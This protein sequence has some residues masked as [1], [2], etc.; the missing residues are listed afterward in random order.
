MEYLILAIAMALLVVLLMGKEYLNSLSFQKKILEKM[1]QDY[2]SLPTRKYGAEEL[3]HICCYYEKHRKEHMIDDITWNDLNMDSIYQMMNSSC[4]AAGDEYLYYRLRTPLYD[5]QELK[6]EERQIRY[7]AE[8]EKER[9]ALQQELWKMGRSGKHS[10]YEYLE[11]LDTL[12]VRTNAKYYL[13]DLLLLAGIGIMFFSLPVGIVFF[14]A[15]SCHNV[16]N[17]YKEYKEVEPYVTSFYYIRRM[18]DGAEQIGR[19]PL[20][21]FGEQ[22][23]RLKECCRA[24]RAF[25]RNSNLVISTEKGSGNPLSVVIDYLRMFLYLD[26]IQF[27][28]TLSELR[29]H[30]TEVD[31]LVT[32]TGRM[33][34]AIVIGSYRAYL[35]DGWCVPEF[36]TE[37]S[38]KAFLQIRDAVHPLLT[39]PVANSIDAQKSVLLTGS[40]ASG[41][42]TFLRTVGVCALLAQTIHTCPAKEYRA[43]LFYIYSSMSLKDDVQSGNSYYM[44][45]VKSIKRIL[46]Q[47]QEAGKEQMKVLCFVDEV[48]RGT[49]TVERISASTQILRMLAR[50]NVVCFAATHDGELTQLLQSV[51]DNYH[52]EEKMEQDDILFPYQLIKGPATTR[53]AIAL[54]RI[55]G[56]DPGIVSQAEEMAKRFLDSGEWSVS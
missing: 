50:E 55:L 12:G 20:D 14:L 15:V 48:L 6:E 23:N 37:K 34:T 19:L 54:L 2:G 44:A 13:F 35:G 52:F 32:I 51:Y 21:D 41:K 45:E 33:E 11:N 9:K 4:S 18:L 3:D 1:Y 39:D 29:S 25:A 7:F 30:L 49:N 16:V 17:Y 5:R 8:H 40:N 28:R 43:P 56:Y 26:L 31:E 53:N 10:I 24:L 36:V 47:V 22:K 46:D 27:N 38:K 42:S